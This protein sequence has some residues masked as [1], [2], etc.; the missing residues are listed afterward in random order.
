MSHQSYKLSSL[1]IENFRQYR[2]TTIKFSQD[3]EKM[4]TIIRGANGAGKTNIMNAI[5]WCLYGTEKHLSDDEKDLPI[6]N[7]RALKDDSKRMINM[8]VVLTLAD[9][10]GDKFKIKR[11]LA[12]YNNQKTSSVVIDPHEKI[13]IPDGSTPSVTQ[14]FQ[15][16]DPMKGGWETTDLINKEVKELLPEDLAV[17]FLFDGEKL[18]DFFEQIDD[19]KKGVEDVSQIQI[20]KKAIDTLEKVI[21][22]K[23]KDAKNLDPKALEYKKHM[24]DKEIALEKNKKDIGTWN[25]KLKTKNMRIAEIEETI[26]KSGGDVGEYQRQ[27]QELK[28]QIERVQEMYDKSKTRLG[29]YVLKHMPSTLMLG[30]IDETLIYINQ[31]AEEGILPPKIRDTFIQELLEAGRCICGND[32]SDGTM[33]RQNISNLLK[34]AQYSQISEI[35]N[36]LKYEL[37]PLRKTDKIT[38]DLNSIQREMLA[39]EKDVD[40][41]TDN[42]KELEAKIGHVDDEQIKKISTE[43]QHLVRDV[44]QMNREL[45]AVQ[46]GTAELQKELES[47]TRSYE[48]ELRKDEKQQH[49]NNQLEFCKNAL[50]SLINVRDKLLEDVRKKVQYYTKEYFLQFL[51]KKGTY[52]GVTIDRDYKITAHHV[53]GY[54]ART[55]LSKG[56]KLVLALS[57]MAALRKITGFGFPLVIDTPLGRVSGEPRHNIALSLP[58]F[59]KNTQVTLLVTDAEYQSQIQDDSNKQKFPAVRDTINKYVGVDYNINFN[60][61]ESN[62][63][64]NK[65]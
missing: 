36:D 4:F 29:D 27:A 1:E 9:H 60:D 38:Q 41:Y 19:T 47:A 8:G 65:N 54:D 48:S 52:D 58:D 16:Y 59:L 64:T 5:T 50:S 25:S 31:K 56:E 30:A 61:A 44:E 46:S 12:L 18:E 15:W 13:P 45:G 55:S 63:V 35:C 11:K 6:V 28:Q 39:H 7:T 14:S 49:L 20:V 51:W 21:S 26:K 53:D 42:L 40:N 33:S 43:R 57:F 34:K 17:Y 24:E 10:N 23:R 3:P 2:N 62:V 22:R 32:I 37:N